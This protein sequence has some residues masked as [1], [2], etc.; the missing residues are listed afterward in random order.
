VKLTYAVRLTALLLLVKRHI[1]VASTM[2]VPKARRPSF[3]FFLFLSPF[4][5]MIWDFSAQQ[6]AP[7]PEQLLF[8]AAARGQSDRVARLCAEHP[9]STAMA[10]VNGQNAF[11]AACKRSHVDVVRLLLELG[12]GIE[13]SKTEDG[14]TGFLIACFEGHIDV[15]K[16]LSSTPGLENAVDDAGNSAMHYA[17]WGGQ[18]K[19]IQYLLSSCFRDNEAAAMSRINNEGM[20][21]LQLAAAGNHVDIV[22]YLSTTS[23]H[24]MQAV[25]DSG[26]NAL[27]RATMHH[28]LGSI[29][30]LLE[31][32]AQ[33]INAKSASGLTA[34]H[35]AAKHGFLEAVQLFLQRDDVDVNAATDFGLTPLSYACVGGYS[36]IA[37]LLLLQPRIDASLLSSN[38]AHA[39]HLAA[40]SGL[41]SVCRVLVAQRGVDVFVRDNEG[42]T[43]IDAAL[44]SGFKELASTLAGW[45]AIALRKKKLLLLAQS[46][47]ARATP[48]KVLF[49]GTGHFESGF[50]LTR[51]ALLPQAPDVL[52]VQCSRADVAKEIADA[53]VVVPLM[54]PITAALVEAAPSLRLVSQFG[55][56]LEGVDI[57]T[58]TQRGVAVCKIESDSCGNAQSCAE[59]A[60]FLALAVLRDFKGLSHSVVSG[61]LGYPTGGTLLG[62]TAL[63]VGFG[64][65]G[66]EL[67][68]RL[69]P[70][71]LKALHV[72]K[73]TPLSENEAAADPLVSSGAVTVTT[74]DALLSDA[75]CPARAATIVFLCCTLNAS[76][77]GSI[78]AAFFKLFPPG[79]VLVNIA[80]GGLINH[81]DLALA[82][83]S[84][85]V[86]G[87]GLDV[88]HTEP[89]PLPEQDG[90]G[91]LA[92]P[93]VVAT[94]HVA[95][96][97]ETSY[98]NMADIIAANVRLL[99][100]G[101]G[102]PFPG[103]VN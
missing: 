102:P 9:P 64:G 58:C 65:L 33:D 51:Q 38:G 8:N 94:P 46:P 27:H 55:V 23:S 6:A 59:H 42:Q 7:S 103:Q 74:M 66:R 32:G 96:V 45:S 22:Q 90:L 3:S 92:H 43:P 76:N 81:E 54:T 71:G 80:R 10:F 28:A 34:L 20:T 37:H 25:S 83:D 39:L 78:N 17:S 41:T 100:K 21:C 77:R 35:F 97:T 50:L 29:K 61:R 26:H 18:L 87:A 4:A 60:V 53:A 63:I 2:Q 5:M 68:L 82:L 86:R 13:T 49:C 36:E 95:G 69:G 40:A 98:Q 85:H 73:R 93:R 62:A 16:L 12:L 57:E 75:A 99:L 67:A 30:L 101:E 91:L 88:Y 31:Q 70:F 56:G 52:V 84:G 14:R 48:L 1:P 44:G 19:V 72:C 89:F 79:L 24:S 11:H 47:R 15:L